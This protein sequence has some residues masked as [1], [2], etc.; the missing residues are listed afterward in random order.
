MSIELAVTPAGRIVAVESDLAASDVAGGRTDEGTD[1]RFERRVAK[2]FASG[3]AEGLFALATERWDRPPQ[4]SFAYWRDFATRYLT[5]LCHT[6]PMVAVEAL[7]VPRPSVAELSTM[8]F[9]VPPMQGVEYLSVDVLGHIWAE[10]DGWS[11]REAAGYCD[12]LAGFLKE[13]AT[14][15]HQVGRVCFHLAENRRDPDYPFAFLA[16]YATG[17]TAGGQVQYQPLSKAL[18]EYAGAKNKQAL[19]HLLS[20]V[21]RASEKS[22][23]AKQLVDSGDLYQPLMWTPREA[24]RFLKNVPI[25][26]ESG[27]LVRT[28]DWWKK[29][30]RPRVGITIGDKHQKKFDAD[31][32]LDFRVQLALGDQELSPAEWR[33]LMAAEDGIVLIK[34]QWVEVDHQRLAEAL[35]HWKKVEQQSHDGLSFVEGMRLLAGAPRELTDDTDG[36]AERQWSFV[37]AGQWLGELLEGLQSPES[38]SQIKPG[39]GLQATLRAYQEIGVRW[40]WFLSRLGLGACLADDMGLGKTVQVLALLVALKKCRGTKPSLLIVPASLLANWKS[41]MQRF[42]PTLRATFVHPSETAK[43]KLRRMAQ[44]PER[45]VQDTDVVVTTYAMLQRQSWLLDISW[46]LAVIDEAQAIKNPAARQ[47]K[48]VKRIQAEARIA[49]TGT[50]VEN[51]LS[52]LW[53]LFDFLCPGLLGSQQKFKGFVKVLNAR[54][55]QRYAPLRKLVQPYILRRLKTDKRVISDLP[56]KTEIRAFCGLG[57]RQ[58]VLYAKMVDEMGRALENLEGMQ[59]RGLVLAYLMRFKQLCNHPSQLL[60]DGQF[61]PEES[62][63]FS[64]LVEICDEIASRQ[65][66]ALV[67]TQF[68]EMTEPLAGF[69][70]GLFGRGGLV[71]HGNT[72]VKR[73]QKLVDHFQRDDGPPFFVLSL[74]AGGTGL[75]LTQASHVI[76]FDRWWNPAVENQAT[77]RAFRIGQQRNVLVHK[78]VCRGTIEEKIDELIEEK[79]QLATDVLEGGAEKMLTEMSDAELIRLVALDVDRASL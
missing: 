14:L 38:L 7:E 45:A 36:D 67:F 39:S 22:E 27:V 28:P 56:D 40:L 1:E 17:L 49:L 9:N 11:R 16:T 12:G 2:R 63:K 34:G 68:R 78:F 18:R 52:D 65:E 53:S 69:L 32:M 24:Y 57:K 74:K 35:Q 10:L 44:R 75:N 58:A 73:R 25:F 21:Q 46:Q 50:P 8:L 4:P 41:E 51:R 15:W 64:R 54:A 20:P 23:L 19:V 59:R 60:G 76:H 29:R 70:S 72:A 13:R 30:P 6:S 66:K 31:M 55:D 71:L 37:H 5:D 62:G 26:E 61:R 42:T 47:T 77:D 48:A 79:K 43:D 3:Q 33:E